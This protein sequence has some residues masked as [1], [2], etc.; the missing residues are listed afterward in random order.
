MKIFSIFDKKISANSVVFTA[1][2]SA[3]AIRSLH[4]ALTDQK[5]EIAKYPADFALYELGEVD[6]T[7]G[8]ITPCDHPKLLIDAH[9]L[10]N[11]IEK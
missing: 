6:M 7:T 11:T 1:L 9:E 5:T 10:M 8:R 4:Q 2:H 3:L